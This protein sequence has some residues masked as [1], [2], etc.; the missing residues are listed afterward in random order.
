[1]Q[2]NGKNH[3]EFG[4][5]KWR[6]EYTPRNFSPVT[7]WAPGALSPRYIRHEKS[8]HNITLRLYI[9]SDNEEQAEE[10]IC[11]LLEECKYGTILFDD[12]P[13]KEYLVILTDAS[14]QAI[15]QFGRILTLNFNADI[16]GDQVTCNLVN[17]INTVNIIGSQKTD[18]YYTITATEDA[19]VI[20]NSTTVSAAAGDTISI[21]SDDCDLQ[22][23]DLTEFPQ[24][25]PGLYTI[26][27]TIPE[28]PTVKLSYR[29]RW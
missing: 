18:I 2:I 27:A 13:G 26:T 10:R 25:S 9:H 19:T 12:L 16:L 4:I 20:L 23:V 15:G 3:E 5:T 1:M 7:F 22:K 11:N 28:S 6:R 14:K 21:K 24:A 29:P 8:L 17:G